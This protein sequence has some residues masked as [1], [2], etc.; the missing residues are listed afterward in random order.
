M[1]RLLTSFFLFLEQFD[2]PEASVSF[3]MESDGI[4]WWNDKVWVNILRK[5]VNIPSNF[6]PL[7]DMIIDNY[8]REIWE[9]SMNEEE[10]DYYQASI[11]FKVDQRLMIITSVITEN[12]QEP[13]SDDYTLNNNEDVNTF[14]DEKN[15]E[16]ITIKYEGGGDDGYIDGKGKGDNGEEYDL[17][18]LLNESERFGTWNEAEWGFPKGRHNNQEKDLL[19]ALREFEEET[20]Y[21]RSTINIIQNLVPFEEIFTGS[22]YKSYKHKYYVAFMENSDEIQMTYQNTEVSKLDWIP[23]TKA[24]ELI[25]PYNLEKKE[26][27]T[28]VETMLTMYNLYNVM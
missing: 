15:I 1:K 27:L 17:L 2:T 9:G 14:L 4:N 3:D 7:F 18:S 11:S 21:V 10:D 5:D 8:G 12:G 22:N 25:R 23:Y 13:A 28:R 16:R 24:L 26:V 19:C 6:L 20:G